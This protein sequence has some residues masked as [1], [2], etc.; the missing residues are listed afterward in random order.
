MNLQQLE[1]WMQGYIRAWNT[2][3]PQDIGQLFAGDARYY[4]APFREPWRGRDMIVDE[5]L[6]RQDEPGTFS[7]RYQILEVT[8]DTGFVRGW[9]QYTDPPRAYSNLWAIKLDN[10]DRCTEFTEWWMEHT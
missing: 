10:Q 9:T 5:W 2:N 7:F 6:N 4:T 3:D 8:S 1:T